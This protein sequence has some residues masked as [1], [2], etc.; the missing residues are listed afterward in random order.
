VPP[1]ELARRVIVL[2]SEHVSHVGGF[3]P[4]AGELA[5]ERDG[6]SFTPRWPFIDGIAYTLL[7]DGARFEIRRPAREA[8]AAV[9]TAVVAIDPS[10]RELPLNALRLYVRFSAPISE[11]SAATAVRI[12]R[13]D[14]GA[15]LEGALLPM[16]PELWDADRTRL[17]VLL[18]PG[19]IKRGLMPHIE[20]GY[21]LQQGAAI[22]VEVGATLRDAAGRPIDAGASRRYAVGPAQRSRVDPRAWRLV[23]PT[24][25]TRDA[26]EV[27]FD[28]PLD[29]GLLEH[30]LALADP[31][32]REVAGDST[33][34]PEERSWSF[35]PARP[36]RRGRHELIIAAR[37]EDIAGNSVTRVFDRDLTDPADDPLEIATHTLAFSCDA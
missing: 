36:W 27:G 1:A 22:V 19:R 10:A 14:S 23:T 33:I 4:I 15:V 12:R 25:Q 13:A 3:Q 17:T 21:P 28:R 32:G 24:A 6:I 8:P 7:I 20:A 34:G 26:L 35:R 11:G 37:L 5:V 2:P 29:R 31:D 16:R 18:D 9:A 30:A